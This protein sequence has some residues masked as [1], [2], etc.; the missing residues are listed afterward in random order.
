MYRPVAHVQRD[1]DL[2]EVR[3]V[4]RPGQQ[5]SP[6][7]PGQSGPDVP[8]GEQLAALRLGDGGG[9]LVGLR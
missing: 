9:V 3:R 8:P 1:G 2:A 4:G 6:D 5:L 7:P